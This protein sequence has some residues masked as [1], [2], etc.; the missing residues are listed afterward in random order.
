MLKGRCDV[1][2]AIRITTA[3]AKNSILYP[4]QIKSRAAE[5]LAARR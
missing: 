1:Y 4:G 5:T 3:F 2:D